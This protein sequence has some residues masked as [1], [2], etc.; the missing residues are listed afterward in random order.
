MS[1]WASARRRIGASI[2]DELL[3]ALTINSQEHEHVLVLGKN[4]LD[5]QAL[6]KSV[7]QVNY[8]SEYDDLRRI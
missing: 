4:A 3:E 6:S 2:P 7:V 5:V 1:L 8:Y